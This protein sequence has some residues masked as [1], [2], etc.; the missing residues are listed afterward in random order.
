MAT[1]G[2]ESGV[3]AYPVAD[4]ELPMLSLHAIAVEAATNGHSWLRLQ[5]WRN[6]VATQPDIPRMSDLSPDQTL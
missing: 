1:I 4:A 5:S 6:S 3:R 2:G